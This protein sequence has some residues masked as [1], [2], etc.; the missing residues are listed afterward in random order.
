VTE[1]LESPPIGSPELMRRLNA[2]RLIHEI[3]Q[4]G[5]LWRADLSRAIGLSKPT[6]HALVDV[7]EEL[8]YITLTSEYQVMNGPGRLGRL[9]S[10]RPDYGHVLSVDIGADK[11]FVS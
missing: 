10:F 11:I 9:Y 3:R 8:G 7:L 4:R 2:A 6:V 5:P 1:T